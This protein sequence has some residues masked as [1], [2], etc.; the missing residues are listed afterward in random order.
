VDSLLPCRGLF[1]KNYVD[2]YSEKGL[3]PWTWD[4]FIWRATKWQMYG[5][6]P[7]VNAE[8][9]EEA[10]E[11]T[12]YVTARDEHGVTKLTGM[13]GP[14]AKAKFDG[15]EG[16]GRNGQA[17]LGC[18]GQGL[19][20]ASE[21]VG[22]LVSPAFGKWKLLMPIIQQDSMFSSGG[23]WGSLSPDGGINFDLSGVGATVKYFTGNKKFFRQML[24]KHGPKMGL[25]AKMLGILKQWDSIPAMMKQMAMP[26]MTAKGIDMQ[27][28]DWL[29]EV[30]SDSPAAVK[31]PAPVAPVAPVA[32]NPAAPTGPA[33]PGSGVGLGS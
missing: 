14:S 26:K 11:R 25:D 15:H 1:T 22:L 19:C 4:E 6:L 8:G 29:G 27:T 2:T 31:T 16:I 24:E 13:Q 7:R 12:G 32:P 28:M 21:E 20:R 18:N 30:M 23:S 9:Q 10:P 5:T 3:K 33:A 17:H